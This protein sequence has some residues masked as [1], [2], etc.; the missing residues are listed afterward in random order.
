MES[1]KLEYLAK[2][3][4]ESKERFYCK[5]C[6]KLCKLGDVIGQFGCNFHPEGF[7]YYDERW[8]CCGK[9]EYT[10]GCTNCDH[11]QSG[12][13]K[14]THENVLGHMYIENL[15]K[16]PKFGFFDPITN[17]FTDFEKKNNG[18]EVDILSIRVRNTM[19]NKN[20]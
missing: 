14:K 20:L 10:K 13:I 1:E 6:K 8:S 19:L 15:Y 2:L 4:Y 5:F 11:S 16:P 12:I 9:R 7:D 3:T 18:I 17:D